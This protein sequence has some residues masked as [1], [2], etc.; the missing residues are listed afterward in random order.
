MGG[1]R[2]DAFIPKA[3]PGELFGHYVH[4]C[5]RDEVFERRGLALSL[6]FVQFHNFVL[7]ATCSRRMERHGERG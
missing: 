7:F 2:A 3:S 5:S 4:I 6:F 1:L